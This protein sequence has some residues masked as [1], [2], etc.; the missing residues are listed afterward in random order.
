MGVLMLVHMLMH[1][2]FSHKGHEWGVCGH[3]LLVVDE[4]TVQFLYEFL[5]L[6]T[7]YQET[8]KVSCWNLGYKLI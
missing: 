3:A 7:C 1:V 8:R 2:S 6:V 5:L 4:A